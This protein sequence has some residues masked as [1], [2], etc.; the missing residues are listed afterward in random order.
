MGA[1]SPSRGTVL[2]VDDDPDLL[3]ALRETLDDA[4]YGVVTV[5]DGLE[6]LEYLAQNP[7]P[8][9]I[10]LDWMMPRCN[11]AEFRR[12]Q[13]AMPAVC[14]VPVVL[15]SADV[16]I[17]EKKDEA[18]AQAFLRKPVGI[19]QLLATVAKYVGE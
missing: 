15:L 16:H 4:G 1:V 12:R 18:E 8:K 19:D 2:V 13:K 3:E 9:L 17:E 11:G 14:D 5:A 6:A 7:R 10:L